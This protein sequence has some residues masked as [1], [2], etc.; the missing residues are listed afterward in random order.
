MSQSLVLEFGLDKDLPESE[1]INFFTLSKVT[2]LSQ[3]LKNSCFLEVTRFNSREP[4][5]ELDRIDSRSPGKNRSQTML[6]SEAGLNVGETTDSLFDEF[7][8]Q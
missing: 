8:F 3:R 1:L 7:H 5:G 6:N 4:S 2:G